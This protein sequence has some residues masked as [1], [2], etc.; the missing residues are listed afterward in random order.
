MTE[1]TTP[2]RDAKRA[3]LPTPP[4][5]CARNCPF[6]IL[7]DAAS[8]PRATIPMA[9]GL[10]SGSATAACASGISPKAA[11]TP[12]K[13]LR[14]HRSAGAVVTTHVEVNQSAD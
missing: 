3:M 2:S 8:R 13:F 12:L 4:G 10:L 6:R 5:V 1:L 9:V 14:A 11:R 7:C